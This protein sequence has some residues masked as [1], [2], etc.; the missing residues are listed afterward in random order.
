MKMRHLFAVKYSGTKDGKNF[1]MTL[2][3][4]S[5]V[6]TNVTSS[7]SFSVIQNADHSIDTVMIDLNR[8]NGK[9]AEGDTLVLTCSA[10]DCQGNV[11]ATYRET[12]TIYVIGATPTLAL[13][14]SG[15]NGDGTRKTDNLVVG[16]DFLTG[17]NKA[18]LCVQTGGTSF[19]KTQ[20]WGLYTE[21]KEEY[22]VK[23]VNGYANFNKLNYEPFD[24]LFLTD[25]PKA[26]KSD[27]AATILDDM[28][29]LVDFR[30][31]FS[32]KTHMVAKTPSK[33]ASKGFTTEP[34]ADTKNAGKLNLNIVCYAHP[35]F[36]AIKTG[37]DVYTD[38]DNVSAPLVYKMLSGEGYEKNKGMQGFEVAAAENFV[39]IGLT[40][41][42]ATITYNSPNAGDVSWSTNSGDRM[43]VTVA[44]RQTN[45][46]ARMILFSLNAGAHSKLT[47][48]GEKVVLKCLEYLLDTDP[49]HVA[50]CSFTF[51][52]GEGNER[53]PEQQAINCP[54]CPPAG[55]HKWSNPANWGPDYRLLPGEFTSV[56]IAAPVEVDLEHAHVMSVR[57]KEGGSVEVPAGKALDVKSTVRHL[58]GWEISP[59]ENS[60]IFLGST[61]SGNGTLIF[62]NDKGDSKAT[63]AMYSKA[64]KE[65][66]KKRYQ[67]IGSP[68]VTA[69]ALYNY[70]GSWIY[71]WTG[72]GWTKVPTGGTVTAWTGY[73]ITQESEG[74]VYVMNGQLASTENQDIAVGAD[75]NMVVG[76]SWTAP[77]DINAFEDAD[78]ENLLGNIYFFNTGVDAT[79][80]AGAASTR[81]QASTYVT[82][83]IHAAPYTGD[84]HIPS[85]QGFFVKSNGAAGVLHLDYS[86][87][88]RGTTRDNILSGQMHAPRRAK[89]G[90]NEPAVLEM[91]VSGTNYDDKLV[92]LERDDFSEGFD[93]GW[94]GEK[95]DGNE[96]AMYLYTMDS[97][98]TEQSVTAVPDLEGMLIGFRAGEE[99]NAYTMHF[100]YK[101]AEEPIYLLDT[102]NNTYTLIET[103]GTYHFQTTDKEKHNRFVLTRRAPQIAT[104]VD[105]AQDDNGAKAV[106]FIKDD[107][108]YIFMRGVLYDATG[109]VV[110]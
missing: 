11:S 106:K 88:V 94:D 8:L 96:A 78:L 38:V 5:G 89:A 55:D 46:E 109:K 99:D 77:I 86:K 62:N 15:A 36:D 87:H 59:T 101:N 108:L 79:G 27:A 105:N 83:P 52:N 6:A 19:D 85:L 1:D 33:W 39:T 23:P 32:F 68:F 103:D 64:K 73:C 41:H 84:D 35:M 42:D 4:N 20:E 82:V 60:D 61:S 34:V 92:L 110:K 74:T 65:S 104:G 26:S 51:D 66:G 57:I 43:L 2:S 49:L 75:Q 29:E 18:D 58:D 98:S 80:T 102:D 53:T 13:I 107:K 24:I 3:R 40:H 21:L 17:Y 71:A 95:W 30:P 22:I 67:Y 91:L 10:I 14:C 97:E 12:I 37:D 47:D 16:G 25:Y 7:N 69:N 72:T 44:E 70:Y 63:V 76:N 93:N 90:V 81:Y 9:Y 100:D 54:S 50:D 56:H 48:K 31:L 45:V 28:Y